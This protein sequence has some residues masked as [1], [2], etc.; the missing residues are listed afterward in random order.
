MSVPVQDPINQVVIVGGETLI[1]WTW[2]LQDENEIVVLKKILA[3]GLI[4]TLTLDADYTVEANDLDNDNGGNITPI[5]SESPVTTGDIWTMFRVTAVDRSPDFAT[6]GAF[7]ALTINEQL[8]ELTRIAQDLN[9]D[10]GN[11]V[12]KDPG[13]GDI[14]NPLIPQP[15]DE[16]ALKFR[17]TG[18]GNFEMVM[19]EFD[20]DTTAADAEASAAAAAA[21]AAAASSSE[22]NAANS[23]TNAAQSASDASDSADEAAA[24]AASLNGLY[25]VSTAKDFSDSPIVPITSENGNLSPIDTSGGNV[26]INLSTLAV[27]A[28]DIRFGFIKIT[29]DSNT[30]TINRGGSDTING[31][32]SLVIS[33]EFESATIAGDVATGKWVNTTAPAAAAA[34]AGSDN[35]NYL[36]DPAFTQF[37]EGTKT[38]VLDNRYTSALIRI[39]T[40]STVVITSSQETADLPVNTHT[41]LNIDITTADASV[42]AGD[43]WGMTYFMTGTDYAQ[44]HN[45]QE[46]NFSFELKTTVGGVFACS[47]RNQA[48]TRCFTHS[49]T[50]AADTWEKF[51]VALLTDTTGTWLFDEASRG[52]QIDITMMGGTTFQ[53]AAEDAW[54]GNNTPAATSQANHMG[55]T[56][57]FIRLANIAL[58]R[59]T[60][61]LAFQPPPLA[62]VIDQVAFYVEL[63]DLTSGAARAVSLVQIRIATSGRVFLKFRIKRTL[64][65]ITVTNATNLQVFHGTGFTSVTALSFGSTTNQTSLGSVTTASVLT[66]GQSGMLALQTGSASILVDARQ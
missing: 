27:Y 42:A 55:S 56:S 11:A 4:V 36:I 47:F 15:V 21:S 23:E 63:F 14:L 45:G 44:I 33:S 17:D 9:R 52:L 30:I 38:G 37:P 34:A 53:S 12:R 62:T 39:D 65:S 40:I 41:G 31:L 66:S 29:S 13:V 2:N 5:G 18:G 60:E 28:I 20:P 1:P 32:T 10:V 46:I 22:T 50:A 59:G 3:T 49:F 58:S 64:P 16:R 54:S 51:S 48:L 25:A 26:V 61:A 19:S 43:F 57:N 8:D 6:S 35:V 7:F 24:S